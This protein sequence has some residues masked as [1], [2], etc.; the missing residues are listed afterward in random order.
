MDQLTWSEIREILHAELTFLPE[1]HRT[2]L[3]FCYLQGN[4]QEEAARLL[5]LS[6][7][8]LKRRLERG[9]ALL[10]ER[11]SRRGLGSAMILLTAAWPVAQATARIPPLL[12]K[13]T[14]QAAVDFATGSTP[15]VSS[16][17]FTLTKGVL[18]MMA[19]RTIKGVAFM[20][21]GW[22]ADDLTDSPTAYFLVRLRVAN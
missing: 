18:N 10:R 21:C 13:S 3:T 4:T 7:G 16:L 12:V 20:A 19:T 5:G 17:A 9:R 11:L 15:A 22:D 6:R 2:A 14:I 1:R 8:T